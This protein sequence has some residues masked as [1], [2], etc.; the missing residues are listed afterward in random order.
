MANININEYGQIIR[1]NLDEDISAYTSLKIILQPKIG[2]TVES[3]SPTLGLSN[4]IEDDK[5]YLKNEYIEYTTQNGDITEAGLWRAKAE[6]TFADRKLI[7]D[8]KLFTVLP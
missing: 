4:V 1:I 5:A 2:E 6:V 3:E 7:S 8:Y